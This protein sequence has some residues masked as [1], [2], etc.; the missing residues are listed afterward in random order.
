[1]GEG[2]SWSMVISRVRHAG[3]WAL[4]VCQCSLSAIGLQSILPLS[5]CQLTYQSVL[6]VKDGK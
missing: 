2:K 4:S 3:P 6:V 1:M 5:L